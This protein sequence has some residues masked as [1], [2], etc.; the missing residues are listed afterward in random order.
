LIP[1][2]VTAPDLASSDSTGLLLRFKQKLLSFNNTKP[3]S[4]NEINRTARLL[5]T[6]F[7]VLSLT[8]EDSRDK[9][10]NVA[11]NN[12]AAAM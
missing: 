6:Y 1:T 10:I 12:L 3:H 8:L 9:Y 11:E 7:T 5:Y 4:A 2:V